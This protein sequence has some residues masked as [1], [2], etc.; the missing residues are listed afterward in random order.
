MDADAAGVADVRGGGA[1]VCPR[2]ISVKLGV[3]RNIYWYRLRLNIAA[4]IHACGDGELVFLHRLFML[5]R[6]YR[7]GRGS[8]IDVAE[9]D[10]VLFRKEQPGEVLRLV[11]PNV[12]HRTWVAL[13]LLQLPRIGEEIAVVMVRVVP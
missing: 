6:I 10:G 8:R 12:L 1:G 7:A 5:G 4:A 11:S 3:Y 13:R 2:V 9:V